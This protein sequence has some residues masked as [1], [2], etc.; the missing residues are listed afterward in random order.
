MLGKFASRVS[1]SQYSAPV[2]CIITPDFTLFA[3]I[4]KMCK[5]FLAPLFNVMNVSFTC[6]A[7]KKRSDYDK[8]SKDFH[9][10]SLLLYVLYFGPILIV[11]IICS[12]KCTK[13]IILNINDCT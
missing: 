9:F 4:K 6:A 12:D 8:I 11:V 5:V 3:V 10:F 1:W 13:I 7:K 2:D